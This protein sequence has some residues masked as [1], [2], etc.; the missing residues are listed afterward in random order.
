MARPYRV[1]PKRLARLV[2][3]PHRPVR[4][5]VAV[6]GMV[7]GVAATVLGAFEYGRYRAGFDGFA[8]RGERARLERELDEA[9]NTISSLRDQVALL[10][11]SIE[12]DH[13]ARN[14]VKGSLAELQD[15]ILELR[16]ELAFYRG[17]VSPEDEESGLKVQSFRLT[18]GAVP[19]IVHF[20]LVLIQ[21]I[22]HD[23]RTMGGVDI[24]VHGMRNGQPA[25]FDYNELS[26]S[27]PG[28]L[29]FSFRYF[30]DFEGEFM[31]PDGFVPS[32]VEIEV[33]PRGGTPIRRSY[34]WVLASS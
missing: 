9:R 7:L 1:R 33:T 26:P 29:A 32:R 30:Q 28:P 10:E 22:K 16:E 23:K 18:A 11:R 13:A 17:I 15:E 8:A 14:E 20:R 2:V 27:L 6:V 4:T 3:R 19:R 21:A 24:V 12:I 31:L 25:R 34:E 5:A